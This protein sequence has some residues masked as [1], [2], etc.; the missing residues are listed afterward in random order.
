M[1]LIFF[2]LLLLLRHSCVYIVYCVSILGGQRNTTLQMNVKVEL[3]RRV[4]LFKEIKTTEHRK[5]NY[6]G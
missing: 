1:R 2:L 3:I 5:H 6:G 4:M